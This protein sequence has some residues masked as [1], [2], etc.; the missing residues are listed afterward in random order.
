MIKIDINELNKYEKFITRGLK[1]AKFLN[2]VPEANEKTRLLFMVE[3]NVIQTDEEGIC[4]FVNSYESSYTNTSFHNFD[5]FVDD[6]VKY[7]TNVYK[8]GSEY[9]VDGVF[10]TYEI[11]K[12]NAKDTVYKTV[13]LNW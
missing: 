7:W 13:E 10:E 6:K 2:Y 11:A 3:G 9:Y 5:V 1:P 4:W 8:K 12:S